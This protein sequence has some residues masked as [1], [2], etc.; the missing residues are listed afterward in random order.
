[1]AYTRWICWPRWSPAHSRSVEAGLTNAKLG[2]FGMSRSL[3]DSTYYTRSGQERVPI[4]WL[5]PECL[6]D[7]RYTHETD[8]WAFGITMW[9][10]FSFGGLPYPNHTALETVMA[11]VAGYRLSSPSDCPP[12]MFDMMLGTWALRPVSN[13]LAVHNITR[14]TLCLV[15]PSC[16]TGWFVAPAL[17]KLT[18]VQYSSLGWSHPDRATSR[19]TGV[20][21]KVLAISWV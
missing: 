12:E 7:R 4:K 11:V 6:R 1:M 5:A 3:T 15:S 2:D 13:L 20:D 9:E 21:G 10:V 16:S 18:V 14:C 8:V 17:R 19:A